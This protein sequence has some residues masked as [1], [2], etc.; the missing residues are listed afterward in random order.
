MVQAR[1]DPALALLVAAL[2]AGP[3]FAAPAAA[4][5]PA[6]AV[7][8]PAA[9]LPGEPVELKTA[10]GWTLHAV[11]SPAPE[12]GKTFLLLHGTGGRKEDWIRLGRLLARK[13]YGYFA[14][15]FRGHGESR[16]APDGSAAHWRK[17]PKP[18]KVYNEWGNMLNDVQTSVDALVGR[19]VA[20]ESIGIVGSE[21]GGSLGLKYAAV[22]PKI[23]MI[24]LLSPGMS[25]Q[26]VTTVNAMRAY[27]NRPI[28]MVYS[29]A[30]KNA[31]KAV[32][33][34]FVFAKA[35]AGE[36]NA[37]TLLAPKERGVRMLRGPTLEQV[38]SWLE[39]PVQPEPL[40]GDTTEQAGVL[41]MPSD[42]SSSDEA[43]EQSP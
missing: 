12:G 6:A 25:H 39:D 32:P 30:D 27:K 42:T 10:D 21:V 36:R 5:A 15:D 7:V 37:M 2:A 28:L 14:V 8:R 24:A 31:A 20:E 41:V 40:P 34:L 38:A 11:Y 23:S 3:A 1:R 9:V 43:D 19:G 16:T 4:P 13:G 29:E 17:F 33:I 35:A 26:E 22:H 18:T